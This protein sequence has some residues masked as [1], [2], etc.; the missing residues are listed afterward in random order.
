[1]PLSEL[2]TLAHIDK[3]AGVAENSSDFSRLI[4]VDVP[5]PQEAQTP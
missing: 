1:M 2:K 4:R 5:S 3:R